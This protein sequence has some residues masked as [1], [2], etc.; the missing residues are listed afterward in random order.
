MVKVFPLLALAHVVSADSGNLF[1]SAAGMPTKVSMP[2]LH[3]TDPSTSR[4]SSV[5]SLPDKDAH[6]ERLEPSWSERAK[7]LMEPLLRSK[8]IDGRT[9][10]EPESFRSLIESWLPWTAT[11]SAQLHDTQPV[12]AFDPDVD[13]AIMMIIDKEPLSSFLEKNVD[14]FVL[15]K[16]LRQT[17]PNGD[18]QAAAAAKHKWDSYFA[19]HSRQED[20]ATQAKGTQELTRYRYD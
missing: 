10:A 4:D 13:A 5:D 15:L 20:D 7:E 3:S 6:E 18:Y 1:A 11:S 8:S 16:A 12:N 9:E 19:L 14:P 17:V 2:D